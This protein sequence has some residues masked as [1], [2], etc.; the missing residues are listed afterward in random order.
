MATKAVPITKLPPG[1]ERPELHFQQRIAGRERYPVSAEYQGQGEWNSPGIGYEDY[2]RM[3]TRERVLAPGR[4]YQTPEWA[5]D[6]ELLQN[7]LVE[8]MES[9]AMMRWRQ[10]GNVK[11]RIENAQ[12][13]IVLYQPVQKRA[14]VSLCREYVELKNAGPLSDDEQERKRLLEAEIEGLDTTLRTSARIA[15]LVAAIVYLYFRQSMNSVEVGAELHIKP[16]HVRQILWRLQRSWERLNGEQP[17]RRN[18]APV[19]HIPIPEN[20]PVCAVDTRYQKYVETC[21]RTGSTP[22]SQLQWLMLYNG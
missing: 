20:P 5:L 1:P 12:Q 13:Q 7:V 4:R 15:A 18:V 14:L 9:R 22:L 2:T 21:A 8:Y 3:Y 17:C 6:N 19:K 16:P 11:E 10:H